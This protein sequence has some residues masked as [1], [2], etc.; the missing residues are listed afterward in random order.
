MAIYLQ[1]F[2]N[3]RMKNLTRLFLLVSLTIFGPLW[4]NVKAQASKPKTVNTNIINLV[5][6]NFPYILET[7]SEG[8]NT[9]IAAEILSEIEKTTDLKIVL[10]NIPWSRAI[11]MVKNGDV[12]GIVGPYKSKEREEFLNYSST[13]FYED[14]MVF[15]KKRETKVKWTGNYTDLIRHHI[16]IVRSWSYGGKF[17]QAM[18]KL[19]TTEASNAETAI[20]MLMNNRGDIVA[21]NR[22]NAIFELRKQ[23]LEQRIE[24]LY[25]ALNV[26]RGYFAFSAKR[27][28]KNYDKFNKA[29][30]ELK[31]SGKL[32]KI[33]D[34]YLKY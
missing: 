12:D 16:I 18:H 14:S 29:L 24:I 22:R 25:P 20:K 10:Q 15:I 8:N 2:N 30:T 6:T 13:P 34:Q 7:D 17:E 28:S 23:E 21:I 5:G 19:A 31:N 9:G 33:S 27:H 3:D 26:N 32:K 11:H 1:L 4:T